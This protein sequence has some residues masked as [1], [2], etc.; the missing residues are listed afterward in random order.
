MSRIRAIQRPLFSS[1]YPP[2]PLQPCF[3]SW[4]FLIIF[5]LHIHTLDLSRIQTTPSS[6]ALLPQLV[7]LD[8]L[9]GLVQDRVQDAGNSEHTSNNGACGGEEVVQGLAGLTHNN[10]RG[11]EGRRMVEGYCAQKKKSDKPLQQ[12]VQAEAE[13]DT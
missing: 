10:L 12:A 5:T 8:H 11:G 6:S 9:D 3:P 1:S 2:P 7:L 4:S 13:A